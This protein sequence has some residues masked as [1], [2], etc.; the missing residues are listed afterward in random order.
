VPG[1]QQHIDELSADIEMDETTGDLLHLHWR[2][3]C[4]QD[5]DWTANS[6]NGRILTIFD[7]TCYDH[8]IERL[9]KINTMDL[10]AYES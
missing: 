5:S 4:P 6:D 3:D 2:L 10:I 8:Y 7:N 9:T 1:L